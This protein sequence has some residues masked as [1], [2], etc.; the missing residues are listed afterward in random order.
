MRLFD[1]NGGFLIQDVVISSR[2]AETSMVFIDSHLVARLLRDIEQIT[3]ID[4]NN[5]NTPTVTYKYDYMDDASKTRVKIIP[6]SVDLI[7]NDLLYN[8]DQHISTSVELL[9][10]AK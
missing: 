8:L 5:N 9:K 6:I 3:V 1:N 7:H 10:V 2:F 4:P